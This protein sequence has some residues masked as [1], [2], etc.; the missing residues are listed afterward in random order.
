MQSPNQKKHPI[1]LGFGHQGKTCGECAW[2]RLRGPGPKV[3]RCVAANNQRINPEWKG[4]SNW[5]DSHDCLDC[6]ACC[7]PAYDAVEVAPRDPV[8]KKQPTWIVAVDGRYQLKRRSDNH[9]SAL[10]NDN[11]CQI[12]QDRPKCCRDFEVGGDN[13]LF[14]RRRL[15][16]TKA[17]R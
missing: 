14:A 15:G 17:W 16:F 9:C 5:E 7:G 12:Y 6:A 8:R 10:L 1:G 11:C 3:L 2:A 4:C 13:C